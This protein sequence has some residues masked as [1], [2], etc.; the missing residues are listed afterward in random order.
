MYTTKKATREQGL[1]AAAAASRAMERSSCC[2]SQ[3]KFKCFSCGEMINRGDNITRCI[4]GSSTGMALRYRGADSSNGLTMRETAF[5]QAESGTNMWVHLGCNPCYW[6]SLP[7]DSNEYSP[8][9]LRPIPTEWGVRVRDEFYDWCENLEDY[10]FRSYP[11]F[12]IIKEYPVEK[13]MKKRII[14]AITRFQAIWR[15]YKARR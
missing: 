7:E 5:Y 3:F 12:C 11:T 9:A 4:R 14:Q 1:K 2:K 8:P 13:S 6:D 15:G 10:E